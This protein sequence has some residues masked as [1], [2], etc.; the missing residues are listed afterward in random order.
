MASEAMTTFDPKRLAA[1]LN[2]AADKPNPDKL[3][4]FDKLSERDVWA[5]IQNMRAKRHTSKEIADVLAA[6]GI[7][8][9]AGSLNATIQKIQKSLRGESNAKPKRETKANKP[10]GSAATS[11]A[12][13]NNPEATKPAAAPTTQSKTLGKKPA[14]GGA[15][16]DEV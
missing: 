9:T 11:E 7:K 8:T 13:P 14:M 3:T 15:F 16:S 4:L 6:N 1:A 5:A 12:T 10:T 2:E